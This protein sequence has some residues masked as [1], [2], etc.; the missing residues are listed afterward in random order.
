L[1]HKITEINKRTI[2][3]WEDK[4]IIPRFDKTVVISIDK[5]NFIEAA[6]SYT[7]FHLMFNPEPEGASKN[8]RYFKNLF[9]NKLE[10]FVLGRSVIVNCKNINCVHTCQDGSGIIEFDDGFR[11]LISKTLRHRLIKHISKLSEFNL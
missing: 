6:G 1:E 7:S 10:M 9:N 2:K 8:L 5:I 4:L 11:Y 3:L